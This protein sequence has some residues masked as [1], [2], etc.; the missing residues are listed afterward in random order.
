MP[1]RH[2]ASGGSL[3]RIVLSVCV[4]IVVL[5]AYGF[6][7]L[8]AFLAPEDALQ[9]ADAIVVL[10]GS[11]M[12]RPM[13]AAD[14]YL[15]GYSRTIVLTRQTRD[16]GELALVARGV[17]FPEDVERVHEAFLELGI[18]R[19]AIV[20]PPRVHNSTAAEAI[21]IRELSAS[22]DWRRV[23]VVSS[24]YHLRRA[25]FA[26]RRELRGMGVEVLMRGTRYDPSDPERWW[27]HRA[28]IRD[29]GPEALK[30]VAYVLGLGA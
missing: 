10:A 28:D 25:R 9:K 15:D 4:L 17:S 3:R 19:E 12:E 30:L 1:P 20:I 24:K 22:H 16:G 14:L 6:I 8:G 23:I 27:R 21:T 7:E 11:T 13:E 26:F 29:V 18:S 2:P 5:G